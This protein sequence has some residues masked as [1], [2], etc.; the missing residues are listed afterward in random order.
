MSG[1]AAS[2]KSIGHLKEYYLQRL[3][4]SEPGA[5]A[6]LSTQLGSAAGGDA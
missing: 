4:K 6:R 1:E 3:A 5:A 2:K